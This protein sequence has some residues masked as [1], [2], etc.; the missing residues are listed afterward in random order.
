ML[1]VPT[2]LRNGLVFMVAQ[3]EKSHSVKSAAADLPRKSSAGHVQGIQE[4]AQGLVKVRLSASPTHH[5]RASL[6]LKP[7]EVAEGSLYKHAVDVPA[8]FTKQAYWPA[9]QGM[10][11]C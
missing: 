2:Y 11:H 10:Q 3:D 8:P 6:T 4:G 5:L 1:K 7:A 9:V